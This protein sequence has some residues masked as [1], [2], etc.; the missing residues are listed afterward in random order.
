MGRKKDQ[1]KTKGCR[2]CGRAK[3]PVRWP[4]MPDGLT[5]RQAWWWFEHRYEK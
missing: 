3:R 5:V 2:K 1:N 4:L